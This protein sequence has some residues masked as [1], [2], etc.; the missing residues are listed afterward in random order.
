MGTQPGAPSGETQR[1]KD[2]LEGT[3]GPAGKRGREGCRGESRSEP[4]RGGGVCGRFGFGGDL[5]GEFSQ[6]VL[7]GQPGFSKA[8]TR[9]QT[10]GPKPSP[11]WGRWAGDVRSRQAG[12]GQGRGLRATCAFN[13]PSVEGCEGA[14]RGQESHYLH[15]DTIPA[16]PVGPRGSR[17][18]CSP[19]CALIIAMKA[20]RSTE[21]KGPAQ[22]HSQSEDTRRACC[23]PFHLL[24]PCDVPRPHSEGKLGQRPLKC[25][26]KERPSNHVL[27]KQMKSSTPLPMQ[28]FN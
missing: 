20:L 11:S 25:H 16:D 27:W 4:G 17:G 26:E 24:L 15:A 18:S 7:T 2:A 1:N 23:P 9:G 12:G 19:P 22:G 3:A 21:E 6:G 5:W 28:G 8:K 13:A 10:L 14:K